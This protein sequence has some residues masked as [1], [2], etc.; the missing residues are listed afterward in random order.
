M[1]IFYDKIP[2]NIQD[3]IDK[4]ER[5]EC[6][7]ILDNPNAWNDFP[8]MVKNVAIKANT[9]PFRVAYEINLPYNDSPSVTFFAPVEKIDIASAECLALLA[10]VRHPEGSP[11]D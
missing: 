9:T 10:G 7:K 5:I 11:N 1:N 8:N 2:Q 6:S 3:I 4:A